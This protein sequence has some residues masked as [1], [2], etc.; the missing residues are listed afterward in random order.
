[1]RDVGQSPLSIT[2]YRAC[3]PVEQLCAR[4]GNLL[5][6]AWMTALFAKRSSLLVDATTD[7][8]PL[9]TSVEAKIASRFPIPILPSFG[10]GFL[11]FLHDV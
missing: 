7:A 5:N 4:S 9:P 8:D 3:L 2:D 6:F 1:M 11:D 10:L